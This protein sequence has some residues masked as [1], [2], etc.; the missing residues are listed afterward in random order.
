[1]L[2]RVSDTDDDDDDDSNHDDDVDDLNSDVL[3]PHHQDGGT[4]DREMH[5]NGYRVAIV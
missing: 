5:V 1:M 3:H 4:L 2:S